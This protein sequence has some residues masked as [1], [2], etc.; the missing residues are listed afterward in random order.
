M[1]SQLGSQ[2][3]ISWFLT[4]EQQMLE[5]GAL[6]L[7]GRRDWNLHSFLGYEKPG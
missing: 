7:C 6:K 4:P 3:E 2:S 1:S 5:K